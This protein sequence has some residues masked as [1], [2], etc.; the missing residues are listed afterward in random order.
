MKKLTTFEIEYYKPSGKLYTTDRFDLEVDWIDDGSPT[1]IPYMNDAFDWIT[2]RRA[3]GLQM[4]GLSGGWK[5]GPIRVSHE[6]G[7][8][9]LIL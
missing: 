3:C 5:D 8:P 6:L 1:G 9:G 2:S 4:P 7:Y